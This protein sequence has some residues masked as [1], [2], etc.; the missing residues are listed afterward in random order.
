MPI[1]ESNPRFIIVIGALKKAI[2]TDFPTRNEIAKINI[3]NIFLLRDFGFLFKNKNKA[4]II[5]FKA[6]MLLKMTTRL[7]ELFILT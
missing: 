2:S 3:P 5:P 4:K 6:P 1:K 7:I